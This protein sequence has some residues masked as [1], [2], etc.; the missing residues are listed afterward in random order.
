MDANYILKYFHFENGAAVQRKMML[1]LTA[2]DADCVKY[3]VQEHLFGTY[4]AVSKL[5]GK[6]I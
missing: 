4:T 6:D 3:Q 5:F 2:F 1:Y